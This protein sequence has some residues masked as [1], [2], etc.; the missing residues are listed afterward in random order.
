[1]LPLYRII[2]LSTSHYETLLLQNLQFPKK[3]RHNGK[4]FTLR[5]QYRLTLTR[6]QPFWPPYPLSYSRLT[7]PSRTPSHHVKM[8][9]TQRHSQPTSPTTPA[10]RT[11]C[12][13]SSSPA[14]SPAMYVL[15][16]GATATR[17]LHYRTSIARL[18][19]SMEWDV[20][21]LI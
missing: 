19:H 15:N 16:S 7:P 21:R 2:Y 3:Y 6:K 9:P 18:V 20:C 4:T 1:L 12:P 13:S 8:P 17:S 10:A 5:F 11:L 14:T